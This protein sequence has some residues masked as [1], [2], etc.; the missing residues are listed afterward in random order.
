MANKRTSVLWA[1]DLFDE[2][3]TL[4]LYTSKVIVAMKKPKETWEQKSN[5]LC[6]LVSSLYD[7]DFKIIN[8]SVDHIINILIDIIGTESNS[9]KMSEMAKDFERYLEGINIEI[10]IFN[11]E[12]IKKVLESEVPKRTNCSPI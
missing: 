10:A 3:S 5:R 7:I 8:D 6:E 11:E 9:K 2:L 4:R 12:A 1:I